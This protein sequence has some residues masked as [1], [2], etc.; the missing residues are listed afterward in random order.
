LGHSDNYIEADPLVTPAHIVPEWYFLL[1]YAIL[2]SIPDKFFGI[3]TLALAILILVILPL[4]SS[5]EIRSM[6][7]RP[8]SRIVFYVFCFVCVMLTFIGGRSVEYPFVILGQ[9]ATIF[10]FCY[11]IYFVPMLEYVESYIWRLRK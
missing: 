8:F 10:Y 5:P 11:F 3:L 7:F 6:N 1:F 9:I 4:F 2:R